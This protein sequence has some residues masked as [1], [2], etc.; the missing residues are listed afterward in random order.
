MIAHWFFIFLISV[1]IVACDAAKYPGLSSPKQPPPQQPAPEQTP[2]EQPVPDQPP[3]VEDSDNTIEI[4][5]SISIA[6]GSFIDGDVNDLNAN[7]APNNSLSDAQ[8]IPN[9]TSLGGYVNV[10]GTGSAGRSFQTGD[11]DD[12]YIVQLFANQSISITTADFNLQTGSPN[13][14]ALF[15]LGQNGEVLLHTEG[16]RQTDFLNVNTTGI[17]YL[18]VFALSGASSYTLTIGLSGQQ[19]AGSNSMASNS[20][21]SVDQD[22][23][24]GEVI[25]EYKQG[26]GI[27]IQQAAGRQSAASI[28]TSLG[29]SYKSGNVKRNMLMKLEPENSRASTFSVLGIQRKAKAN[30]KQLQHKLDTIEVVKA[31]RKRPDIV[32]ARLNYIRQSFQEPDDEFYNYQWHYPQIKLP[33]AWDVTT[34]NN[35][36]IVAVIDTGVLL[37][38][39]DLQGQLVPGYDF[40]RD[41][42][43][44]ADGNGIDDNPYDEGD[45]PNGNSSFHGTH[46]SGTIA[47]SSNNNNG[48]SGIAWGAKVM[49]LRALGRFG[50][51]DY[52]IEQAVRFAAQLP[53]DSG[54]I[55]TQKADV[56]NLSLGGPTNSTI[57]SEAFRLAREA[58]VIVVAASGN[59]ASSGINYPASL[60][61]VVSVSATT[62]NNALAPYSNFGNTVDIAAPGGDFADRN[63]DGY[64][65]GVLSTAASDANGVLEFGYAFFQGT[66]MAA[67]HVA[68][69]AALMKSANNSLTPDEFDQLLA[70]G[71]ITQDLGATGRDN[72]FGY[73]LVD[74]YKAVTA[75]GSLVDTPIDLRPPLVVAQPTALNFGATILSME[76]H[77]SN[78]G[79]GELQVLQITNDSN[80]WLNVSEVSVDNNGIGRYIVQVDRQSL[81]QVTQ[82]YSATIT[83]TTSV[84]IVTVP[85]LMQV[86]VENFEDNAGFHYALLQDSVTQETIQKVDAQFINGEYQF[87]FSNVGIGSYIISAGTD[88]DNDGQLCEVAEACGT[89]LMPTYVVP[90]VVDSASGNRDGINFETSF[91]NVINAGSTQ[92]PM[93]KLNQSLY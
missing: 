50:G 84:N 47:A 1:G 55:P 77:V 21:L 17:Y 48:V 70:N 64:V 13:R 31:L 79:D 58:G 18:R 30:N 37:D 11:S 78:A 54:T 93:I 3:A 69:V 19:Q 25:V 80:G 22:F 15:L 53:N 4:S 73:G 74:A 62:I 87:S 45:D 59:E 41:P 9:P 16:N 63:G 46:V 61:G 44:A 82:A 92:S 34:G 66:S 67:P 91:D 72:Q 42:D 27:S 35:N 32:S 43:N 10:A 5:G 6:P 86:Y 71:E 14:I 39:P 65:D 33:Q 38:H 24:P 52:D 7:Y 90:I 56:I 76:L 89:Y 49:P 83:I 88:S 57:P 26:N 23:V 8:P 60:D 12:Y 68:G 75:A 36:V 81:S 29:L 20:I 85:V 28:A 51:T 2:P 40:I